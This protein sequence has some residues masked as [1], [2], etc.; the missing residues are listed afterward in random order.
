MPPR[1][2]EE[3]RESN[4]QKEGHGV[5][6]FSDLIPS[7]GKQQQD[8][9]HEQHDL[10]TLPLAS[11]AVPAAGLLSTALARDNSGS[12][13]STALAG[14]AGTSSACPPD[15]PD[16]STPLGAT[17]VDEFQTAADQAMI[18]QAVIDHA[19]HV[20]FEQ[21]RETMSELVTQVSMV[22]LSCMPLAD[23]GRWAGQEQRWPG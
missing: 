9:C 16:E 22:Y 21:E 23:G 19:V 8:E 12:G 13:L 7:F 11:H 10:D 15:S 4:E 20:A 1:K 17:E 18:D 14:A 5:A 2:D 3:E 6:G